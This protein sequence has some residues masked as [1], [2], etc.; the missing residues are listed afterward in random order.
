MQI[1]AAN[2]LTTTQKENTMSSINSIG[3]GG[4]QMMSGMK[5]PDPA[6][7]VDNLFSK[8]DTTNK[9]YLE[10]S[11]LQSAV[12]Q[13]T[14]S[15]S[16]NS[17]GNSTANVDEMFNKL[18]S[19]SDGKLTKDEMTSGMKKLAD[20][21][22]SQ[23]N[24]M[25]MSGAMGDGQQT[26]SGAMP[27]P[28]PDGDSAGFTKD[29]LTSMSKTLASTDSA[30][31]SAMSDIANNFDK[32]DSN[33]DGKVNGQE[34][35]AYKQGNQ[36]GSSGGGIPAMG[37]MPPPPPSGGAHG[38]SGASSSASSSSTSSSSSS[39]N[40]YE[41][42]DTNQD[43]TVSLQEQIAY[44]LSSQD[45]TSS[46]SGNSNNAASAINSDARILKQIMELMHT[47][48]SSDSTSNNSSLSVS[49]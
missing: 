18:D 12:S 49:A 35:M 16:S 19:N 11:D 17:T 26:S 20:T 25:R 48:S 1:I 5:R 28:P 33:G 30:R 44:A 42:A 9:G 38:A 22:D 8:L 43:G 21:L 31:A 2:Y 27:P 40:T 4:F 14:G 6:K 7:M 41:A 46:T 45:D 39:T 23:F 15:G 29:Q 24:Q 13:L 47:Y 32:A 36:S 3:S 37:D 34:A 10:K